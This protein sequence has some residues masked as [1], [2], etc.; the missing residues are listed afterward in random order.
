MDAIEKLRFEAREKRDRAI[1]QAKAEYSDA[2]KA[3]RSVKRKLRGTQPQTRVRR[4]ESSEFSAMSAVAAAEVVLRE[5]GP[6]TLVEIA[7]EVQARGCRAADEPRKLINNLRASLKYHATRFEL[8]KD[9][10][11]VSL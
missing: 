8:G 1:K 7:A 6:L 11:W 2:L 5:R 4:P 9:G 10:R 3:I